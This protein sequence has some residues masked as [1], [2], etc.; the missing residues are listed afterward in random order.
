MTFSRAIPRFRLAGAAFLVAAASSAWGWS[1]AQHIQ[2]NKA[3]G[4][5]VPDEMAAFRPFSRA[6]V[7]PGIY[8]D[9]W[10]EAD[11]AETPRHFFEPD[12]LPAG[13]DIR[14]LSPDRT[15]AFA[16]QISVRPDEIGIAPWAITDLLRQMTDAMRTNDWLWAARCGAAMGHYVGDL[17]MP[18]HCTKNYNGDETWQ[19]GVHTRMEGEM[20]KAFFRPDLMEP[21]PAVYLENPFREIMGWTAHSAALA[22]AILNAD[23][24]AK[25]SANGRID[26]ESYYQKFWELTGDAIVQQIAS[27]VTHLSSLWYTAWVDAGRPP[28][29]APFDELPTASVYSGVGIDPLA[30][31]GPVGATAPRQN[32]TYDHI[33][34]AVMGLVALIVIL[35]SLYRGHQAKNRGK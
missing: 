34:W 26:T 15:Q 9:L 11:L 2:I 20:T 10:K 6:M 14:E 32:K 17:H 13:T 22:P 12:R 21:A 18:L 8:P 24:A 3:A 31:G 23:L 28:I 29:P 4:R 33:I 1:G 30:E 19:Q 25:R 7:L 16:Q 27:A 5:Q 35:S